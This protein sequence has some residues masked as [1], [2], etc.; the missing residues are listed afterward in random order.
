MDE[1]TKLLVG[2]AAAVAADSAFCF[3]NFLRK[4]DAVGLTAQ[5]IQ[6]ASDIGDQVK[7]KAQITI[8][9]SI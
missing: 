6:E 3:M 4:W 8:K 9:R 7:N 5:D 1:K 2:L